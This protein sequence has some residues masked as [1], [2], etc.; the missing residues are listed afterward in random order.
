MRYLRLIA[1]FL[2]TSV[3]EEM[4]YP[5]NFWIH[6][7]NA[8]LGLAVGV[9][10]VSIP[11]SQA[12]QI[13]GWDYP[14]ALALLGVYLV[15][16][17]LRG[18]F[19]G[20][21][22]ESLAGMDGD[23]WKGQFDFTLA[24]PLNVQFHITFRKWSLYSLL[25]LALGVG[26]IV[27]AMQSAPAAGVG[28]LLAFGLALLCAMAALYAVLLA[29]TALVFWSPGFMFTWVFDALMQL[30]R[31]PVSIY[32]AWLRIIL[33]WIIPVGLVTTIPAQVLTREFS[34][35]LLA[36]ALAVSG[37]LVGAASRLFQ[38]GLRRYASASS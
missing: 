5:A 19:L 34:P 7:L 11:F 33:T 37:L 16:V 10:G 27:T 6:C 32:P 20:P 18:L 26:V 15:A 1:T 36:G 35:W 24:R 3:Q 4:A 14:S 29:F 28:R 8:V 31:Y 12:G 13:G 17:A 21:G 2:R 38:A 22:L 9:L 23:I 25:D 30:A